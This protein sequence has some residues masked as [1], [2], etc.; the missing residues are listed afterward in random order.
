MLAHTQIIAIDYI[1]SSFPQAGRAYP[2]SN[3]HKER[4]PIHHQAGMLAY[5]HTHKYTCRVHI[6]LY[7]RICIPT[8]SLSHT[9]TQQRLK[10][11][12]PEMYEAAVSTSAPPCHLCCI[13]YLYIL[14]KPVKIKFHYTVSS[15]CSLTFQ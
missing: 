8:H 4:V 10:L 3:G 11:W 14:S 1:C 9:H 15:S 6:S 7:I 13:C 5:T 2:R 12:T